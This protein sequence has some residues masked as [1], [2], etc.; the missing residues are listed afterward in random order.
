M[1]E[2]DRAKHIQSTANVETSIISLPGVE[3]DDRRVAH[4]RVDVEKDGRAVRG[5]EVHRETVVG[6]GPG[7][8]LFV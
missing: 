2:K 1:R 3:D 6:N 7:A 8:G 5:L 4:A